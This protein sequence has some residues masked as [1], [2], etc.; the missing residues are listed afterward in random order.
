MRKKVLILTS[1]ALLLTLVLA[2]PASASNRIPISGSGRTTETSNF[3]VTPVGNRCF[4]KEDGVDEFFSGDMKGRGTFQYRSLVQG[5]CEAGPGVYKETWQA[6]ET[7]TGTVLNSEPGTARWDCTGKFLL[8]PG[9]WV[10]HCAF[11]SGTGGLAGLHGATD[12]TC[13]YEGDC[14]SYSGWVHFDGK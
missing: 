7:F 1:T 13:Y 5:T 14:F 12:Y 11:R 9:R 10:A 3:T 4:I 8:N 6:D 2:I